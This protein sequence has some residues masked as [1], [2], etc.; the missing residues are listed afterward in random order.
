[1]SSENFDKKIS[2]EEIDQE[3][4]T[5]FSEYKPTFKIALE[6][7]KYSMTTAQD[8]SELKELFILRYDCFLRD[9]EKKDGI[10]LDLD[11]FDLVCDHLVIRCNETQKVVGTYRMIPSSV[12]N[13]FYSQSEFNL[14][15]FLKVDGIK[16]ELG[17]ACIEENHRNGYVIDLLWRGIAEYCKV[18]SARFLFGCSS[19]NETSPIIARQ[20]V[21]YFKNRGEHLDDF[22]VKPI[23][24]YDMNLD[25][26]SLEPNEEAVLKKIVPSLLR[27]YLNAGAKIYGHPALDEDFACID[28]F[29]IID[30]DHLNPSYR[31][32]YFK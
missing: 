27:S 18:T 8:L 4:S 15:D 10:Q 29:N 13:E 3:L 16:V 1:M 21:E 11:K 28:F 26:V 23:G 9:I 6:T 24:K 30:L 17:R 12:S 5:R 22:D 7:K 31:K 25:S 32:R 20:L 14:D 2:H 19:I